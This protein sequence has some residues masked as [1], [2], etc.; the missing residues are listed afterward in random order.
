MNKKYYVKGNIIVKTPFFS[1][2]NAGAGFETMPEGCEILSETDLEIDD[3]HPQSFF[4]EYYAQKD[5]VEGYIHSGLFWCNFD[6]IYSAYLD[7]ISEARKFQMIPCDS[8]YRDILFRQ[9]YLI[10]IASVDTYI[11]DTILARIMNN[12]DLFE[13][14]ATD[15]IEASKQRRLH[16]F[17]LND[18]RTKYEK[19][20]GYDSFSTTLLVSIYQKH[21]E[22][23]K[24]C[25]EL[26]NKYNLNFVY[27]DFRVGFREGQSKAR[28]LGLYM[29]K[30]CGCIFS[31]ESRY[32]NPNPPKAVL[33]TGCEDI[34][35]RTVCVKKI[36]NKEDYIDLFLEADPSKA[37]IDK[38]LSN[39][40]VYGL[41]VDE[42]IVSLA[43]ILHIDSKTLELK[44]LVT[45][46]EY[47]GKELLLKIYLSI[48]M[49]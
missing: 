32:N 31:E 37:C 45:R 21:D 40:D 36:D 43:V 38:Y 34:N 39:S 49:K 10:I 20:N 9:V 41:Q 25:E 23:K 6:D 11:A 2:L 28:E 1:Y 19:E 44:N 12:K 5:F 46:E 16:R 33:P 7:R 30:Y 22:I 35:R 27:R 26:A 48:L 47:R 8:I 14:Y 18:E 4:A 3:D 29:Q 24:I 17:L 13:A 42:N 15:I